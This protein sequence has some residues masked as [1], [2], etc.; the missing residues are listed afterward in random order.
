MRDLIR[1][2]L[3]TGWKDCEK[4]EKQPVPN[5]AGHRPEPQHVW[6]GLSNRYIEVLADSTSHSEGLQIRGIALN[7]DKAGTVG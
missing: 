7:F 4:H 2:H 6:P 3:M 1:L 5:L